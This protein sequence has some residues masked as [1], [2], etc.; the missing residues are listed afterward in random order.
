MPLFSKARQAL[1][2]SNDMSQ[3]LTL[4]AEERLV[5]VYAEDSFS[6][7]QLKGYL[8]AL[9]SD[10]GV[11]YHY[12]TS[13][14]EDPLFENRPEGA[15]VWFIRDQLA[16][17]VGNL[18][19]GVFLTTMPDLGQFH[20]PR[21]KKGRTIYAFHSLN[22]AHTAYRP[23]AFEH[24]D[25]FLCTGPHHVEELS[26]LR[27]DN[28]PVLSETGY[29]KLDLIREEF[30]DFCASSTPDADLVVV[31][32]SWGPSNV[33]EAVGFELITSLLRSDLRVIVRPHPQF[34]HSLYPEG[35]GVVDGL[36]AEFGTDP[37]VE[38]EMSIDTQ[39][40]FLRSGLMISDWSGAA[41]EFALGTAR[42]V[43]FVDT[44]QKIFNPLWGSLGIPS[45]EESMRE[46]V[47]T[48]VSLDDVAGVGDSA[49]ALVGAA[50]H[51]ATELRELA[52]S[53]VFNPGTSAA[54]GAA[55]LADSL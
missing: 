51:H 54:A 34:F 16:R 25:H 22:S 4:P 20:V 7:V 45:F 40:S 13:D 37:R 10:H 8:E 32:P 52:G 49:R 27:A 6:Y 30:E 36:V 38:F 3:L 17:F 53:L 44:P 19:C 41:Y 1:R 15:T 42:P 2:E 28:P 48:V 35:K 33:L 47:G 46:A 55:A 11:P 29:Y 31:A 24:Y 39:D 5:V 14:P 26:A 21:P 43:L 12:V 23:G 9:W 18:E 50:K